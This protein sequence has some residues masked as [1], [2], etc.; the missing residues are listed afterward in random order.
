[1]SPFNNAYPRSEAVRPSRSAMRL[2]I[3]SSDLL[4][5]ITIWPSFFSGLWG[6]FVHIGGI[7]EKVIRPEK[8]RA[9]AYSEQ[10]H[11]NLEALRRLLGE[12]ASFHQQFGSDMADALFRLLDRIRLSIRIYQ[13]IPQSC[14]YLSIG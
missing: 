6:V 9:A 2:K 3:S 14:H 13:C 12:S 7:G 4:R 10:P 1:M 8:Y 5:W 11:A